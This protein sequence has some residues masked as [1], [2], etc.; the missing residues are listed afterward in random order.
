VLQILERAER[1]GVRAGEET[2]RLGKRL[3]VAVE[4]LEVR[5]LLPRDLL[6]EERPQDDGRGTGVLEALDA[7]QIIGQRSCSRDDRMRKLHPEII[8]AE[9]H[10][11]PPLPERQA[12]RRHRSSPR[13]AAR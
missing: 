7:V 10:V 2:R 3:G 8:R 9:V 12:P 6:L 11:I 13:V 5:Q 4:V 1:E